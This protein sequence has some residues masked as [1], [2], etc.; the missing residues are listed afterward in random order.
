MSF[1]SILTFIG[2]IIAVLALMPR[3][4]LL[5]IKVK[6]SWVDGLIIIFCFLTILYLLFYKTFY[7]FNISPGWNLHRWKITPSNSI[8]IILF[9]LTF[10]LFLRI[11]YFTFAIRK[12]KKVGR[13]FDNLIQEEKYNDLIEFIDINFGRL[14]KIS[15]RKTNYLKLRDRAN[16]KDYT[17]EHFLLEEKRASKLDRIMNFFLIPLRVLPDYNNASSDA[18]IILSKVI[19]HETFIDHIVKSHSYVFLK[20]FEIDKHYRDDFVDL[21]FRKLLAD[22]RSVLFIELENTQNLHHYSNYW[23]IDTNKLIYYLF[24][25]PKIAEKLGVW[26]PVGEYVI[27]K[28]DY[29]KRHPELDSYNTNIQNFYD[30]SRWKSDIFIAIHFFDVMVSQALYKNIQWHMWLSYYHYFVE[31]ITKNHNNTDIYYD[32]YAEWPTKYEYLIYEIFSNMRNWLRSLD[33]LN[34]KQENVQL[35][36]M[37]LTMNNGRIPMSTMNSI[38]RCL[39]T[40]YDSS[41]ISDHFKYYIFSIMFDLYFDLR[42]NDLLID[43]SKVLAKA[44]YYKFDYAREN[45]QEYYLF[46]EDTFENHYDKIPIQFELLLEFRE[47]I[48]NHANNM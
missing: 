20:F 8:F 10:Y 26:R 46:I 5:F 18:S 36:N 37:N 44:I 14:K 23:I 1:D 25:D 45:L 29:L 40:L 24:D 43:H 39:K 19:L 16:K 22:N 3:A 35:G 7:V 15:E 30:S 13:M 31:G 33:E 38:G 41:T 6:I 32:Q 27:E 12:V 28:L 2:I 42:K 34:L 9:F 17:F 21:I 4:K 11:K 48:K 47:I